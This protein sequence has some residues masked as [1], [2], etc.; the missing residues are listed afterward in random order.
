LR[1]WL[2]GDSTRAEDISGT[3]TTTLTITDDSKKLVTVTCTVT[4]A[5]CIAFGAGGL[6]LDLNGFTMTGRARS[7]HH[8]LH[9]RRR[10]PGRG[11]RHLRQRF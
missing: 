11:V 2:S 10:H 6:T 5:A 8:G 1:F 4:G 9:R 3:I 7:G